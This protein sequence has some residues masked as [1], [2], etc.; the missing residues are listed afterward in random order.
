VPGLFG[1][2]SADANEKI[3]SLCK[4]LKHYN[5]QKVEKTYLNEGKIGIGRIYLENVFNENTQLN[6]SINN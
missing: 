2:V 4:V 3:E 5:W 1:L 6:I